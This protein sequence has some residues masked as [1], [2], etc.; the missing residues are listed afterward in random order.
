MPTVFLFQLQLYIQH[1]KT[2]NFHI[3]VISSNTSFISPIMK[4]GDK[5]RIFHSL[6]FEIQTV[7]DQNPS[8]IKSPSGRSFKLYLKDKNL[9]FD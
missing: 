6:G 9:I 8:K 7:S 1:S 4:I 3:L 2:E 5:V